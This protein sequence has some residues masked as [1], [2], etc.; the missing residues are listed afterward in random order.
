MNENGG[1]NSKSRRRN[2]MSKTTTTQPKSN[3][4]GCE[5]EFVVHQDFSASH[6]HQQNLNRRR[7]TRRR[8]S[9]DGAQNGEKEKQFEGRKSGAA[10][11]DITI[12]TGNIYAQDNSTGVPKTPSF[13][14]KRTRPNRH[15]SSTSSSENSINETENHKSEMAKEKL[16]SRAGGYSK[17]KPS[18]KKRGKAYKT[19][20]INQVSSESSQSTENEPDKLSRNGRRFH[21][22]Q[23]ES[24]EESF[25]S[26]SYESTESDEESDQES[27]ILENTTKDNI[28]EYQSE[29]CTYDAKK[30]QLVESLVW[31]SHHTPRAVLEDLIE[32]EIKL[33]E[34]V[35]WN[36]MSAIKESMDHVENSENLDNSLSSGSG[37]FSSLSDDD[38]Y[39]GN[40]SQSI[41]R[42]EKRTSLKK[43]SPGAMFTM[44]KVVERE[45]ALLFV[46]I[47]G[48]TK[49]STLLDVE[50]LSKVIN[51]YF[52]MIVTEV[53]KHGG[54]ILKFAGD[55]FFAEWKLS[56][57]SVNTGKSNPLA[58]LNASLSSLVLENK[59]ENGEYTL[60]SAVL[61][62]SKCAAVLVEKF[63][64]YEISVTHSQ[65]LSGDND[66]INEAKLNLHCG[67]GCGK[68]VGLHVGDYKEGQE[69]DGV[70]LRREF[71]IL[72]DPIDQVSVAGD[73]AKNGEV[74]ASPQAL[75]ALSCCC[76]DMPMDMR[77]SDVPLCITLR[78]KTMFSLGTALRQEKNLEFELANHEDIL[79]E[80]LRTQSFE[81]NQAALAR[82]HLQMALYVHPVIRD[83]ELALSA[84]I[85]AGKVS[86]PQNSIESRLLSEAELRSV[87]IMFIKAV[88][89]PTITGDRKVDQTL[90][91]LLADIMHVT[92]R[93]LDRYSGH[94]RQFIV[95]DKGVVMI[96][97]FGLRGSTFPNM[98]AN[99][100]LPATFSIHKTLK[101]ELKVENRIGATFGKVYCGVVGGV[102]RHEFAVMGAAVNLA[103]RLMSSKLNR[104]ILLDEAVQAQADSRFEFK[105]LPPVTAKGYDKPV[106]VAEPIQSST[107][108]K[109][110]KA[111]VPFV[112]REEEKREIIA[113]ADA[114]L[115]NRTMSQSSMIFLMGECGIGKTA[116]AVAAIGDI[117]KRCV[118]LDKKVFSARSRTS[119]SEQ[120]MPLSSFRKV[121]LSMIRDVS[122]VSDDSSISSVRR[123]NRSLPM[124][125]I[126]NGSIKSESIKG[127][128][129]STKDL[130][131]SKGHGNYL[132]SL[133]GGGGGETS[134]SESSGGIYENDSEKKR[135]KLRRMRQE[136]NGSDLSSESSL[137][138]MPML[139]D[140]EG[141][142]SSG[143]FESS[144]F[145]SSSGHSSRPI[146]QQGFSARS[147]SQGSNSF[148][149]DY[150][151]SRKG[152]RS[153]GMGSP[154]S[155]RLIRDDAVSGRRGSARPFRSKR[156]S[157]RNAGIAG[158][159]YSQRSSS[160]GNI[161]PKR[162]SVKGGLH[163][164]KHHKG[165]ST[166]NFATDDDA[167]VD[168]TVAR[169]SGSTMMAFE[170]L[171]WACE[172]IGYPYEYADIVGSEFL[173]LDGASPI[174][175]VDGHVPT[176]DEL[177]NFLTLAFIAIAEVADLT[178]IF[179]DDFQWVD[180]FT[181]K[182]FRE[183]SQKA[184]KFL[185]ICAMR[186]HDKQ[187]L[188]R[189]S[190]A[191]G[192][193]QM[194]ATQMQM[195]EILLAPLD[196]LEIRSMIAKGLGYGEDA[197]HEN[198]CSDIYQRTA[199]L[200][201]F[202]LELLEDIKRNK[203]VIVDDNGILR[204]TEEAKE[205]QK[206]KAA[207]KG[208]VMEETFLSRFD[209]LDVRVR[210]VLQTCAVLGLSFYLS[211]VIRV[212][213]ELK[214]SE[215]THAI[216]NAV[217][218]IILI[219][220]FEDKDEDS[221][222]SEADFA[223]IDDSFGCESITQP[224]IRDGTA[225]KENENNED[226]DDRY[227]EFTH[228][229]WRA[230]VLTT[231]L[232]ERKI[233]LHRLIAEEMEKDQV[234]ILEQSDISRLL[235]LF[236]HW[237]ACG[238][239]CKS[240]PLALAVGSRL[241]EWDLAVQSLELY[242][243][244][245]EMSFESV[246]A[247]GRN[248]GRDD[249]WVQ[250]SAHPEI[251]D[252]ILR[253]H[254]RIGL[255]HQRLGDEH[256]SVMTFEDA[257]KILK[258]SSN[259]PG[260]SRSLMMPIISTLCALKL[261]RPAFDQQSRREQAALIQIFVLEAQ[262]NGDPVHI[263][264]A[265]S[266]ASMYFANQGQFER[267]LDVQEQLQV[268]YDVQLHSEEMVDV[269]G[270]DYAAESYAE[271]VQWYYLMEK[272]DEAERQ[273]EFV[274]E[275]IVPLQDPVDIGNMLTLSLPVIHV[276]KLLDRGIDADILFK[277]YIINAYHDYVTPDSEFWVP[278][279]NPMAYL[280][281]VIKMEEE[282]IFDPDIL[283]EIEEW[284]LDDENSEF[285]LELERKAHTWMGELC[286]RLANLKDENDPSRGKLVEK[287][288]NLLG[289]VCRLSHSEIFLKQLANALLE[290][291]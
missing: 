193:T 151:G 90:Y 256:E 200:P 283:M 63:S 274:I 78:D 255:C 37:S 48:F 98:V 160:R 94:L 242:R 84:A 7:R 176:S 17:R 195:V 85:R 245:L 118:E 240:A 117:K 59:S 51:S 148:V 40:F 281:E 164:S 175:H 280:L 35:R 170:K 250:V 249:D 47:S 203:Y 248:G 27:G 5:R 54:D 167:S 228:A 258:T 178:V 2:R 25:S 134:D 286:W 81:L 137:S 56:D 113:A 87:Y 130:N 268:V 199:G 80:A 104:G 224:S 91:N 1:G 147:L 145:E 75:A 254:I 211:D 79:Y 43:S 158:K 221:D 76:G 177:V 270:Y 262:E 93:E 273:A 181:W 23:F 52:N 189:L 129:N 208:A 260:M 206:L 99:N 97:T 156:K 41:L 111:T 243:D 227:F 165:S 67:V 257:Y 39:D 30:S 24:E 128:S 77:K 131:R 252:L 162:K 105:N 123:S 88:I 152:V 44:P 11:R 138:E 166:K 269:Y 186:S 65:L 266:M 259:I 180:S 22:Q 213:P 114:I 107:K 174:T 282:E 144:A 231:M 226:R 121:F 96:A 220:Q 49:L 34:G 216:D 119:E 278:L 184:N 287:A 139:D 239:F 92:S 202:V 188:R 155:K 13:V 234:L 244:A 272:H 38:F 61:A 136:S 115:E 191:A 3:G 42:L 161:V 183:L 154:S 196:L 237:K 157:F 70:E 291:L 236:D 36:R 217:N 53:I 32:H 82:L 261:E 207:K 55:A 182:I 289:P 264:R 233:E 86:Q 57:E 127:A 50:S 140:M 238:D 172:Q 100:G 33:F 168:A 263:S 112:G 125:T 232:K 45:G 29:P 10:Q 143:N 6:P 110:K 276:F 251:L 288:K 192:A 116:L 159:M 133:L 18:T 4:V 62:A 135:H 194:G 9:P 74:Y 14:K 132:P 15:T 201:V 218:E 212:H 66:G 209:A 149:P 69:E 247:V 169:F 279:F 187:A 235:T 185:L 215:I 225:S 73:M 210:K 150:S 190:A 277:K 126:K 223:S 163:G 46:D 214:E 71:L 153:M 31:F 89:T 253:L 171:C 60:S 120:R 83:D 106:A 197:V 284:V 21:K 285:H 108:N 246:E 142:N 267:A 95:D 122:Q 19:S 219:E 20:T 275:R 64:D 72:G 8:P 179:V 271:S 205:V 204:W 198:L 290:A 265:L 241:E 12:D 109:K 101:T 124:S 230:K 16:P 229:M 103:A 26:E 141:M 102:R 173:G 68:M 28:D 58:T 146:S 222:A